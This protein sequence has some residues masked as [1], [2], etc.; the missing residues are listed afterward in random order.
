VRSDSDLGAGFCDFRDIVDL[1]ERCSTHIFLKVNMP[2]D[3]THRGQ[4]NVKGEKLAALTKVKS[5][6]T[7]L[8][9]PPRHF[10]RNFFF[11]KNI[12]SDSLLDPVSDGDYES[13]VIFVKKC[14]G[15]VKLEKNTSPICG[16]F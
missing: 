6:R 7:C 3:T 14:I 11:Y 13:V 8:D 2:L 10:F 16:R 1:C 12:P 5:G 9:L 4:Q 15:K